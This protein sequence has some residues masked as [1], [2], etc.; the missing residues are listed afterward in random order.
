MKQ[1]LNEQVSRIK[2]MMGLNESIFDW[3][4][5]SKKSED[6][7]SDV[8]DELAKDPEYVKSE[9]ERFTCEDCGAR[10]YNMYM[11]NKDIWDR[12]GNKE[13]TLCKSC[14]EKR[15]GR[16]LTGDDIS[17]YKDALTNKYNPELKKF[18]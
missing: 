17:Q 6:K 9:E 3:F 4:K 7:G 11:V 2:Q 16:E 12:Y 8:W 5:S 14:L 1:N 15:M 13:K 18:Y 10:D